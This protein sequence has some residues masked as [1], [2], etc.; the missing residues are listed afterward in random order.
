MRGERTVQIN[1]LLQIEEQLEIKGKL[2]TQEPNAFPHIAPPPLPE[3]E[4]GDAEAQ[5]EEEAKKDGKK[6]WET[7]DIKIMWLN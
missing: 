7:N 4:E 3:P 5:T 2:K 1:R 6:K